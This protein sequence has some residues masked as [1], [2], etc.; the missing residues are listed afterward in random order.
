[1]RETAGDAA[2][3]RSPSRGDDGFS[4]TEVMIAMLLMVIVLFAMISVVVLALRVTAG[5]ATLAT[6]TESVQSRIEAARKVATTGS[7]TSISDV[8]EP[9][10]TLAD[11]RGAQ[12]TVSGVVDS[13]DDSLDSQ[14]VRVT[15]T[16]TE[17]NGGEAGVTTSVTTDIFIKVPE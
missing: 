11:G 12:Y 17:I 2:A 7:C 14:V 15:V 4:L 13:C 6:A 10:E 8:I 9:S 3:R 5:N 16:A 1:M